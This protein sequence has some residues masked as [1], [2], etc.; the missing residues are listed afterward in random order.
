M[1]WYELA[2]VAESYARICQQS[3]AIGHALV[4]GIEEDEKAT[5]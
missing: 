2:P 5:H 4:S 3:R 1:A